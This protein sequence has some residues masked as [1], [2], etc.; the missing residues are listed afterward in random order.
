M[1]ARSPP[2]PTVS[3]SAL[4]CAH[5]DRRLLHLAWLNL[6]DNAVKYSVGVPDPRIEIWAD[7]KETETI[8]HVRDNGIVFDMEYYDKLFGVFQRLHSN[9]AYPGT[10]VGLA[11]AHRVIA[12]HD[13]RIWA[14]SESGKGATF[15]FA[16]PVTQVTH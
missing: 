5:G 11:I 3:I 12:R 8:Y 15:S 14:F 16:L 9:P 1:L 2:L 13:G 6:L 7:A 4:P 10:G